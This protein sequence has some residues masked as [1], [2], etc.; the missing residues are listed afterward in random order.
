MGLY[1]KVSFTQGVHIFWPYDLSFKVSESQEYRL[2]YT[3]ESHYYDYQLIF[4]ARWAGRDSVISH[5]GF[6][7]VHR[8]ML[9][10]VHLI[11]PYI[12]HDRWSGRTAPSTVGF[13]GNLG[14]AL[15]TNVEHLLIWEICHLTF[16]PSQLTDTWSPSGVKR[17]GR[18]KMWLDSVCTV[19]SF[20]TNPG[21]C[22]ANGQTSCIHYWDKACPLVVQ[23]GF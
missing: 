5:G 10:L 12:K 21:W 14:H 1:W 18:Q 23:H 15:Q 9:T 7:H 20:F 16:A 19:C 13:I 11:A 6:S 4:K 8:A 2:K 3:V 17:C 22:K